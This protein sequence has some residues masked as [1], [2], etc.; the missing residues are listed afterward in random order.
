MA[1]IYVLKQ[2]VFDIIPYNTFFGI[3][4]L[5]HYYLKHSISVS[6]FEILEYWLDIGR[7]D[8]YEK[9]QEQFK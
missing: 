6:K 7:I 3:D 2:E 5:V 4:Q 8:D 9:A 1:G